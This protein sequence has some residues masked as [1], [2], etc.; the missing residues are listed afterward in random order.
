MKVMSNPTTA[1]E[2]L[3]IIKQLDDGDVAVVVKAILGEVCM[4]H[5]CKDDGSCHGCPFTGSLCRSLHKFVYNIG[6]CNEE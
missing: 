4:K 1:Q 5:L 3:E 2:L 6:G